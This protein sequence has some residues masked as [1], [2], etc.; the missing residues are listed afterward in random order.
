[1]RVKLQ[2]IFDPKAN[3]TF[4]GLIDI[5]RIP[6][7]L[8]V[9]SGGKQFSWEVRKP[10]IGESANSLLRHLNSR[11]IPSVFIRISEADS[12]FG[13]VEEAY[14]TPEEEETCIGP[15]LKLVRSLGVEFQ[16]LPL[17]I[18]KLLDELA[19]AN[20]QTQ[21]FGLNIEPNDFELREYSRAEVDQ[22]ISQ[23]LGELTQ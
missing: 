10:R 15:I 22:H 17:T 21:A 6:Y 2:G 5:N 3:E 9:V 14:L 4:I 20:Y 23:L 1:M 7:H 18:F 16:N 11:N 19:N 8:L 13:K 12:T